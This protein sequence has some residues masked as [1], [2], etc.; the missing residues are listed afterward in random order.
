[1]SSPTRETILKSLRTQGKC[2]VKELAEAADI[3]PISVRHH[4]SSL[5]AEGL[6]ALEEARHGVGRPYHLY[7]LTDKG[8]ERF[9]RR[10]YRLTSHILQ[11]LKGSL[12][13]KKLMEIFAGVASSM[14]DARIHEFEGLNLQDRIKNLG[15]LLSEEGFEVEIEHKGDEL[16]IHELSCPYFRIGK[17]YPEVC[18]IDQTFIAN[19]LMVPV[20]NVTC[21]IKGDS[22]CT[23]SVQLKET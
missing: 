4:L 23:F 10:Y 1:M 13:E 20:T 18:M 11:E 5:Q 7:F 22:C 14:S 2:T 6:V 16:V 9:P 17:S 12:P 19:A 3:S 15:N 8:L 21:I